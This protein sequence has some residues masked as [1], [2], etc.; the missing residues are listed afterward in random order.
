ML[1]GRLG[2]AELLEI[3]VTCASTVRSVTNSRATIGFVDKSSEAVGQPRWTGLVAGGWA[4]LD[5]RAEC[6]DTSGHG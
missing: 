4:Y 6:D 5:L 2:E 3:W 1:V